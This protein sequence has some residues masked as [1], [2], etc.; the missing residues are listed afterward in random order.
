MPVRVEK[1]EG[2]LENAKEYWRKLGRIE[3]GQEVLKMP[4]SI[5][6]SQGWYVRAK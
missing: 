5:G 6:D 3:D 4:G 1:G 2:V